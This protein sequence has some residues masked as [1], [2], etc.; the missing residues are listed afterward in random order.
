MIKVTSPQRYLTW[1][2]H[3]INNSKES[4][5]TLYNLHLLNWAMSVTNCKH[6]LVWITILIQD[7]RDIILHRLEVFMWLLSYYMKNTHTKH[8]TYSM[9]IHTSHNTRAQ[10]VHTH[11]TQTPTTHM[12]MHAHS[13]ACT[14]TCKHA[15]TRTHTHT[16]T[17]TC[18]RTH[19]HTHTHKH[20][21]FKHNTKRKQNTW[22][23]TL[24]FVC[25]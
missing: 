15:R 1:E 14:R 11:N 9:C 8:T 2:Y 24:Y 12:H 18:T 23:K 13:Q 6:I 4:S 3:Y 22:Q 7:E 10:H 20:R 19:T 25:W 5:N 16:R 17:R 21:E